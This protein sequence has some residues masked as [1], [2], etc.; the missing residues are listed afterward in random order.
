MGRSEDEAALRDM[1][2]LGPEPLAGPAAPIIKAYL[3]LAS[4][5]V[6]DRWEDVPDVLAGLGARTGATSADL[7]AAL[8]ASDGTPCPI[9]ATATA[10]RAAATARPGR[11]ALA[12]WLAD[13][14]LARWLGWPLGVPL[15]TLG[16][17]AGTPAFGTRSAA[18]TENA[19]AAAVLRG[20]GRALDRFAA[21]NR[22]ATALQALQPRL[23]TRH[24]GRVIERLL[25][26]DAVSASRVRD[27][28]P[29]RA[30]RRLL[31]RLVNLDGVRELTG[32]T[33]SR[34]YGL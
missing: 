9:H 17:S 16:L 2:G 6:G 11:D 29:E 26:Q 23:R 3:W 25:A 34:L 1:V 21:L 27:L 12:L 8:A 7:A 10:A 14:A 24:A 5:A 31:T 22:Q 20:A 32:R 19:M 15:V 18:E 13:L 28:V 4:G 30:A 33:T